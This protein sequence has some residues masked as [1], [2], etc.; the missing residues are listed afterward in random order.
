MSN[1][2]YLDVE[3]TLD[4]PPERVLAGAIEQGLAEVMVIGHTE[5]GELYLAS[6]GGDSKDL[7]W[8]L[9]AAKREV[10]DGYDR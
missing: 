5:K 2:T 4:I 6:S 1:V 10:L 9:E 3:T 7:L 8:L